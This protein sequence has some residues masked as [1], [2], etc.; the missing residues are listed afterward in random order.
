MTNE[1]LLEILSSF[2]LQK[3]R[4]EMVQSWQS[5]SQRFHHMKLL[6]TITNYVLRGIKFS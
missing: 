1:L 3:R 4:L 6:E 5:T 2:V